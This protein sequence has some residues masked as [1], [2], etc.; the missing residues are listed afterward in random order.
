[1]NTSL[2]SSNLIDEKIWGGTIR[3][4]LPLYLFCIRA[5]P[6]GASYKLT[7]SQ[8]RFNIW[9]LAKGQWSC[10][11]F[12]VVSLPLLQPLKP[13]LLLPRFW[14]FFLRFRHIFTAFLLKQSPKYFLLC[15]VGTALFNLHCLHWYAFWHK[16]G[17]SFTFF[18]LQM[19]VPKRVF[20]RQPQ[21]IMPRM[22]RHWTDDALFFPVLY[23]LMRRCKAQNWG[24]AF[25]LLYSWTVFRFALWIWTFFAKQALFIPQVND[26]P[27]LFWIFLLIRN[28]Y[29]SG[30]DL[31]PLNCKPL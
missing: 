28:N 11:V 15:L 8:I 1:M 18:L 13:P 9:S 4:Y 17:S 31:S 25:N 10:L 26:W 16:Y 14:N 6:N 29:V 22:F 30:L 19:D 2:K 20:S 21:L 5:L 7:R 12:P 24:H 27:L 3:M 23:I